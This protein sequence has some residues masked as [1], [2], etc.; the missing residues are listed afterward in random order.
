MT[1]RE[2]VLRTCPNFDTDNIYQK[3]GLGAL[4]LAGESGEVVDLIK[5][6]LYHGKPLEKEKLIKELGDVHWYL[7]Y[8]AATLGTT[9]EEI[10]AA[11]V[12][13]LRARYPEG[14]NFQAANARADEVAK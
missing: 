11:N 9:T 2:N 12:A 1:Y 8:L 4:G 5:K 14:F 7:E 6:V 10:Q 13:K 3:L